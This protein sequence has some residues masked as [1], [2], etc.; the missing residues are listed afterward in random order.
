MAAQLR[1]V[2]GGCRAC[3]GENMTWICFDTFQC[4]LFREC[5]AVR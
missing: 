5:F 2:I 3:I 1:D 4:I